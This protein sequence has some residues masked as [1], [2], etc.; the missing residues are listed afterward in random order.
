MGWDGMEMELDRVLSISELIGISHV[1]GASTSMA[2][3]YGFS[4]E[5]FDW[6]TLGYDGKVH[7]AE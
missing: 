4:V 3:M 6:F 1:P 5:C 2:S 7:F